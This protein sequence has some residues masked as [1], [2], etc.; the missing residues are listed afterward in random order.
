MKRNVSNI[1]VK[2]Y[3]LWTLWLVSKTHTQTHIHAGSPVSSG[4]CE[5]LPYTRGQLFCRLC[6]QRFL[7]CIIALWVVNLLHKISLSRGQIEELRIRLFVIGEMSGLSKLISCEFSLGLKMTRTYWT[8]W[9]VD[10][11]SVKTYYLTMWPPARPELLCPKRPEIFF[12]I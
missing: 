5:L 11:A 6:H 4:S 7:V 9:S 12:F 10:V 3:F 1:F 8:L 2:L